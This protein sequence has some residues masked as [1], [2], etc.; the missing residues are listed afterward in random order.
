MYQDF[1]LFIAGNWERGATNATVMSPVTETP[2]G[3]V[4]TATAADT[5]R[6]IDAAA[7]ASAPLSEMGGFARAD[8]LHRIA[9][10]MPVRADRAA[11]L[12]SPETGQP[13]AQA[14][15]EWVLSVDDVRWNT[16]EPRRT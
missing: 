10:E 3:D 13:L 4:A 6:A 11:R 8:A 16:E 15:R 9:D 1:G 12:I 5:K 14:G 7:S 2:L